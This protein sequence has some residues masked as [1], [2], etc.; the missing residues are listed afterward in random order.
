MK[1]KRLLTLVMAVCMVISV[2]PAMMASAEKLATDNFEDYTKNVGTRIPLGTE[3]IWSSYG[4]RVFSETTWQPI[5]GT[6][7]ED[8]TNKVL[9]L[10]KPL[11]TTDGQTLSII[12]NNADAK[13]RISITFDL[14][15]PT[16]ETY[17]N[18]TLYNDTSLNV[19]DENKT[20]QFQAIST[21]DATSDF[22]NGVLL[23]LNR[24][25]DGGTPKFGMGGKWYNISYNKW[26][27]I[28][29]VVDTTTKTVE[30]YLTGKSTPDTT[31]TFGTTYDFDYFKICMKPQIQSSLAYIDNVNVVVVDDAYA[32]EADADAIEIDSVISGEVTLPT[33]GANGSAITWASNVDGLI[34]DNKIIP[35]TSSVTAT[36]T[37]TVTCGT[38]TETRTFD[39]KVLKAGTIFADD[40]ERELGSTVGVNGWTKHTPDNNNTL[41]TVAEDVNDLENPTNRV[42]KVNKLA[43]ETANSNV[44]QRYIDRNAT[45][46]DF[47]VSFRM[48]S[49]TESQY[50]MQIIDDNGGR[51][52]AFDLSFNYS[53]NA[54]AVSG[55]DTVNGK[56][57]QILYIDAG[58]LEINKWQ[59]IK[60]SFDMS[61]KKFWLYVDGENLTTTAI[62]FE[63]SVPAIAAVRFRG[64][65]D[66]STTAGKGESILLVDD[67]EIVSEAAPVAGDIQ[68]MYKNFSGFANRDTFS[69]VR[70]GYIWKVN[71]AD[72]YVGKTAVFAIYGSENEIETEHLRMLSVKVVT[73]E[74][75]TAIDHKISPYGKKMKIFIIDE[76]GGLNPVLDTPLTESIGYLGHEEV[77]EAE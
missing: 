63:N 42:L 67:L 37:A 25:G 55:Q 56:S 8:P 52:V 75:A 29:F 51:K 33:A 28:K 77:E 40:F 50:H 71:V 2:F 74:S 27:P 45:T 46:N 66:P 68:V 11:T 20:I 48:K 32:A 57:G 43:E 76:I 4:N 6:D 62:P 9:R 61:E 22:F 36:L 70:E 1:L 41:F 15:V 14:Y 39:V 19:R 24:G 18:G 73:L 34:V 64:L 17:G 38:A 44:I 3:H 21:K 5:L 30:Y 35:G 13:G 7:P 26:C 16:G 72:E 47:A 10:D 54:I 31:T 12:T 60:I 53:Q 58:C 65:A 59:D 23:H 49:E 69:P